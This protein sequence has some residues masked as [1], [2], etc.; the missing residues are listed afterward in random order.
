LER[1]SKAGMIISP[2]YGLSQVPCPHAGE[3]DPGRTQP[4]YFSSF[5]PLRMSGIEENTGIFVLNA[6]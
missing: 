3:R 6:S 4:N 1:G 2:V 5:S